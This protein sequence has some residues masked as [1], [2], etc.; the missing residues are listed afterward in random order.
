MIGVFNDAIN[1]PPSI[2]M[3]PEKLLRLVPSWRCARQNAI[4]LAKCRRANG[5]GRS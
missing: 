4:P 2:P 1:F 3:H 5:Q